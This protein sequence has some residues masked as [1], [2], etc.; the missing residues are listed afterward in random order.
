MA[1]DTQSPSAVPDT[2]VRTWSMAALAADAALDRPRASMMAA[3]RCWTVGR[4]VPSIQ[5]WSSMSS[6]AILPLTSAWK[7][8]GYWVAEWLPQMVMW[9]MSFTVVPVLAASWAMARL[10]SRRVMAVKRPL[11]MFGAL[12]MAMSELVLA[13]LPTTR[14]RTSD[15]ALSL[16]AL[17]CTV[18]MAPLA[19]RRSLRS[20][21]LL[22][23]R[24][25]T[26]SP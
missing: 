17:P 18:K 6:A 8:S 13:G 22:R 3:P 7:R 11:S 9:V 25:P 1:I 26:S 4:N 14:M 15:A 2:Q 24:E 16:S 19:S 23:G 21:P 12:F 10:W 20:M 5:A